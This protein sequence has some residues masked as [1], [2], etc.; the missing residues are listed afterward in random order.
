MDAWREGPIMDKSTRQIVDQSHR[1]GVQ[2]LMADLTVAQTFLDVAEV[3]RSDEVRKRNRE[4]ARAAYRTV[5]RLMPK[6]L[7]SA[8]ERAA[9]DFKL[10][11]LK[12]RLL[13]SGCQIH[14]EAE[15]CAETRELHLILNG[16]PRH[17]CDR[18]FCRRL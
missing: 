2:F 3:S 5:L 13:A 18:R 11:E 14:S 12:A 15:E 16:C 6:V 7:P 1:I 8:H 4:N 9:L 17:Y 10:T